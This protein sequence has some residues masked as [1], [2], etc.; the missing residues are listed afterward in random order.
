MNESMD[1]GMKKLGK[2]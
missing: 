1:E 2:I